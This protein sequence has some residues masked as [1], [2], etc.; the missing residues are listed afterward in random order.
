MESSINDIK[1]ASK[2]LKENK[3]KSTTGTNTKKKIPDSKAV[4]KPKKL[5]K[6]PDQSNDDSVDI[7]IDTN[8]NTVSQYLSLDNLQDNLL[9]VA[10]IALTQ[11]SYGLFVVASI[12]IFFYGEYASV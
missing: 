4:K 10:F 6:N 5:L 3:V 1:L 2:K 9:N 8:S 7:E 12:G 11:R